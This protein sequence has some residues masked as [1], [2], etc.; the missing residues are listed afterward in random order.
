MN[1]MTP[2]AASPCSPAPSVSVLPAASCCAPSAPSAGRRFTA[3]LAELSEDLDKPAVAA[4]LIALGIALFAPRQLG[5]S[6]SFTLE[7]LLHIMPWLAL[8][9]ALAAWATASRAD[10]L[11]ANAFTGSPVRMI[12]LGALF[13]A[14]SPFCSCG[15]VPVI[16][17]LLGAGVPL[18]PVMAFWMSSPLVDPEMFVMLAASLGLE[19]AIAKTIAAVVIGVAGGAITHFAVTRGYVVAALRNIPTGCSTRQRQAEAVQWNVFREPGTR[20][21]FI[22]AALSNGA[23]LLRWMVI[24]FMLESLMIAYLPAGKVAGFL[25]E[26]A[27]AIPLAVIIG[28]PAYINGYAALPLMRGLMDLG[29][30][31]AVALSFLISGGVSSIPAA[32]A[33]WALVKPRVFALYLGLAITGSLLAG[34]AYSFYRHLM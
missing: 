31:P 17:G 8:S 19:F 34:Y 27:A 14:F 4:A 1:T 3:R 6:M 2:P 26:G 30:D 24:A 13:G 33:V 12:A 21:A 5:D 9:V 23:F 25:G 7:S 10:T 15:V 16:A 29:M 22:D 18:A 32:T 20:L 28:V 11:I